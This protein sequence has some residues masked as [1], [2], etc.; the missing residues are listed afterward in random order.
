[1]FSLG[2][3]TPSRAKD[4][5]EIPYWSEK[6]LGFRIFA[7]SCANVFGVPEFVEFKKL[8]GQRGLLCH[9]PATNG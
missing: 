4:A 5:A 9:C 3:S 8:A 7:I 1:M 2:S 6:H